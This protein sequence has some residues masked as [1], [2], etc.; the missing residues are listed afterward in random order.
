MTNIIWTWH[1]NGP[2]HL[3]L[4]NP[5]LTTTYLTSFY[6]WRY[7]FLI[8]SPSQN[9]LLPPYLAWT[10]WPS[11]S[12]VLMDPLFFTLSW[13]LP[14]WGSLTQLS[15]LLLPDWWALLEIYKLY[16]VFKPTSHSSKTI[17]AWFSS[18][19]LKS[20]RKKFWHPRTTTKVKTWYTPGTCLCTLY[21]LTHWI[22]WWQW[23]N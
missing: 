15:L 6:L 8:C 1:R 3:K 21:M 16:V 10:P 13:V 11:V 19:L 22:L 20:S 9:L 2:S 14:C 18:S 17:C 7:F 5:T 23:G 4:S 12:R